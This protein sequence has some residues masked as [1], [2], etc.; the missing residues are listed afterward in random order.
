[1][2]D[3][4]RRA[5]LRGVTAEMLALQISPEMLWEAL[6]LHGYAETLTTQIGVDPKGVAVRF[7]GFVNPCYWQ[8]RTGLVK[9][10]FLGG[11]IRGDD[12]PTC[13]CALIK[14]RLEQDIP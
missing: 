3:A 12:R 4:L 1:M 5:S 14:S 7:D 13:T 8:P 6:K 10:W 11:C 9:P 2:S